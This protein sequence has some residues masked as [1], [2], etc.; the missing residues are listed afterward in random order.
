MAIPRSRGAKS[1]AKKSHNVAT[2]VRRSR[3]RTPAAM[4]RVFGP[5][6]RT[7]PMP[8]R[9]G[10]VAIAAIVSACHMS[11]FRPLYHACNLPLLCNGQNVI[12]QPV[13]HQ[14]G[15]EEEKEHA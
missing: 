11:G 9:P 7:T 4:S 3:F 14:S 1:A 2:R 8:A 6:T 13:K 10:G 15:G 12:H 5:E